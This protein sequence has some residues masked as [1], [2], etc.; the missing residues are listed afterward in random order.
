M[1]YQRPEFLI[2]ISREFLEI[3][4]GDFNSRGFQREKEFAYCEKFFCPENFAFG[5]NVGCK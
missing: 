5:K 4:S 1:Q 3:S 2:E